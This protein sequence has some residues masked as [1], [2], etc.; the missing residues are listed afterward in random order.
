MRGVCSRLH[1]LTLL[2]VA[3]GG[4]RWRSLAADVGAAAGTPATEQI[5][6]LRD[7]GIDQKLDA[8]FRSI[9]RSST[10]QAAT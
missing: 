3:G 2:L 7:V 5:P 9:S 10:R 4:P 8:R 1:R 6:M